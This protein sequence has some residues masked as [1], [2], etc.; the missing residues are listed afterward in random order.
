MAR[1]AKNVILTYRIHY[2]VMNSVFPICK[3][4]PYE[5]EKQTTL[6]VTNLEKSNVKIPQTITWDQVKLPE[7]WLLE[8]AIEPEKPK[9]RKLEDIIEH[10]NGD[11]E[12]RFSDTRVARLNMRQPS[13]VSTSSVPL[14]SF[15][16]ENIKGTCVSHSGINHPEYFFEF[17]RKMYALQK[18][19]FPDFKDERVISTLE[20]S[21][22][23]FKTISGKII[24]SIHPPEMNLSIKTLEGEILV[25]P[26]KGSLAGKFED[27]VSQNNFTN[28][29]LK[30]LGDQMNRIEKVSQNTEVENFGLN[31]GP[32]RDSKV[33]FKPKPSHKLDI[34]FCPN[35]SSEMIG[36]IAKR[37]GHYANKCKMKKKINSLSIDEGLKKSLEKIL[38]SESDE[39]LKVAAIS[40]SDNNS[41]ENSKDEESDCNGKEKEVSPADLTR[42]ISSIK[43]EIIDLKQRISLLEL[44]QKDNPD[45]EQEEP[46]SSGLKE[47]PLT[48]IN[49]SNKV[50]THKWYIQ[51]TIIVQ[52]EFY[53]KAR[54]MVDSGA[55]LNCIN[56][57][58]I[59][60]RY[61]SKTSE[62]LNT[63]N[64]K[65]LWV[66]Y[67]LEN[68]ASYKAACAKT[69]EQLK[70][71]TLEKTPK[72]RRLRDDAYALAIRSSLQKNGKV[73]YTVA[74]KSQKKKEPVISHEWG[75]NPIVL[76][77]KVR[78][79]FEDFC[80]TNQSMKFKELMFATLYQVPWILKWDVV[81]R[82]VP[83]KKLEV[84]QGH[85]PY[86]GRRILIKWWEKFEF[87]E[88]SVFS[89]RGII[90]LEPAKA[91]PPPATPNRDLAGILG[92]LIKSSP[93]KDLKDLRR[94]L[95]QKLSEEGSDEEET[96]KFSEVIRIMMTLCLTLN[97]HDYDHD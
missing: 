50:I 26:Y 48:F 49:M 67:K 88:E 14:S 13:R 34:N 58:L 81:I 69:Q 57:G 77:D 35:V 75:L 21:L 10:S 12:I 24:K 86:L 25:S 11:V 85:I 18:R 96:E 20:T 22:K 28:L 51:V 62:I 71:E 65:K 56:E 73:T 66:N 78:K 70:A 33:L 7:N 94:L 23:D 55:D 61:F 39:E 97:S 17:L 83:I 46:E 63:E 27:I 2:K 84:L 15:E 42:E 19:D 64:G 9:P 41:S 8:E 44:N 30:T 76:P 37:P 47:N 93:R 82:S 60:Y 87:F 59:P 43:K 4:I 79:V 80:E 45:S 68:A 89:K 53:V 72:E 16:K 6:F 5:S 52:K 91:P 31:F 54:A 90:N 95:Q 32:K 74:E 36:E 1:E 38:I 29:Y 40:A 3:E 92:E